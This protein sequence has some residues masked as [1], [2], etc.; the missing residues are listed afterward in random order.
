MKL[1]VNAPGKLILLGEYAVLEGARSLVAAVDRYAQVTIQ[2]NFGETYRLSSPTLGVQC[3]PLSAN[4]QGSVEFLESIS[5]RDQNRLR[6]V[7]KLLTHCFAGRSLHEQGSSRADLSIRTDAFYHESGVKLG[8]GS[9]AAMTVALCAGL[10][11][12]FQ[13]TPELPPE[14]NALFDQSLEAHRAAQGKLGSGIDVAAS[15]YGNVLCYRADTG[16]HHRWEVT[17]LEGWP[18]DLY[19]LTI[20]TGI[21]ASTTRFVKRLNQYKRQN[22][23]EYKESM[24]ELI[25]LSEDGSE[26]FQRSR[27]S[28]FLETADKYYYMLQ[29]LGSEAGIPIISEEHRQ[30]REI[31]QK[32]GGVYKP[33]GAG[34]GDIGV[35]LTDN[36][37]VRDDIRER[38]SASACQ[39]LPLSISAQGVHLT[40]KAD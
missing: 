24:A 27:W 15:T 25:R 3:L 16:K 10:Q 13:D 17:S 39:L 9:S 4:E 2:P 38:I 31:V 11:S 23:R 34:A 33:S 30:I 32:A 7:Q 35:A 20:W 5:K 18:E 28:E 40:P 22:L 29:Q 26:Y 8:L 21:P 36:P 37:D 19:L 6:F 1:T 12:Y 14:K